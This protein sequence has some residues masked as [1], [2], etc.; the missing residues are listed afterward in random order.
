[1]HGGRR[2]RRR[3]HNVLHAP[4]PGVRA[5]PHAEA[6]QRAAAA[7]RPEHLA[8]HARPRLEARRHAVAAHVLLAELLLPAVR[9][10]LA[11]LLARNLR[12]H[13]PARLAHVAVLLPLRPPT[14]APART[15]PRP[16]RSACTRRAWHSVWW[17]RSNTQHPPQSRPPVAGS[18]SSVAARRP[19]DPAALRLP[20]AHLRL[21]R[22]S[23]RS[24]C[25]TACA[26]PGTRI[27]PRSSSPARR[28]A[29]TRGSATRR[30]AASEAPAGCTAAPPGTSRR[31]STAAQTIVMALLCEKLSG[32]R[33]GRSNH[34]RRR[35]RK[36]KW[37]MG[38]SNPRPPV[39]ETGAL[40]LS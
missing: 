27:R 39:C 14:P 18:Q 20:V 3:H 9:V 4:A 24:A 19:R 23:R 15:P 13:G 10:G 11:P 28:T 40:P 12:A 17:H 34:P 29:T 36:K 31:P 6:R 30:R 1:M 7:L 25:T 26:C 21:L 5:A 37:R 22:I 16:A 35:R 33:V 32:L 38:G 2:A 8:L